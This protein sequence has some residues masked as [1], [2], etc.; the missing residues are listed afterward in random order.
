[1]IR[2]AA[3]LGALL[4]VSCGVPSRQPV[5]VKATHALVDLRGYDFKHDG[6]V[7]PSHWAW[8]AGT[9]WSPA[10][11]RPST[12][13]PPRYL[14][15]PE[16][17]GT[18]VDGL[19]RPYLPGES[20]GLAVATAQVTFLV[21]PGTSLGLQIG[22]FPGAQRVWVNGVRVLERGTP[23]LD[24]AVYRAGGFG[25]L[26]AVQPR[27]GLLSIVVEMATND[28]LVYH[29]ELGRQW[30]LESFETMELERSTVLFWHGMQSAVITFTSLAFLLLGILR[31]GRK[32][33]L[34]VALFLLSCLFKLLFTV[35][36]AQPADYLLAGIL[37]T[38][39]YL[40]LHHGF[41]LAPLPLL[42]W[43]LFQQFPREFSVRFAWGFTL[44]TL[45]AVIW[46]L[47][48]LLA[49][50]GGWEAIYR[51]FMQWNWALVVGGF[52][53]ASLLVVLERLS[54]VLQRRRPMAV[55]YFLA[56]TVL[57]LSV[58]LPTFL[59]LFFQ[60][61]FTLYFGWGIA[62]FLI[63]VSWDLI[64]LDLRSSEK[65]IWRLRRRI[66][67]LSVL[68]NF[69]SQQWT[70]RMGKAQT[71][72]LRSG[73]RQATLGSLVDVSCELDPAVW[74]TQ[75]SGTVKKFHA[76]LLRSH[77]ERYVWLTDQSP[78]SGLG[79]AFELEK[80]LHSFG[81]Q[82]RI[83]VIGTVGELRLIGGPD[84]WFL[85]LR[86][87]PEVHLER[88]MNLAMATSAAVVVDGGLGPG[89]IAG[90]WRSY[91]RLSLEG[92]EIEVFE[93]EPE[94]FCGLKSQTLASYEEALDCFAAG[95]HA[96][97]RALLAEVLRQNPL[98]G[99][100]RYFLRLSDKA[101]LVSRS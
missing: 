98:D 79:M 63:V 33:Q 94:P 21:P 45:G 48:P 80:I 19:F 4:L 70:F 99:A 57:C 3:L 52:A 41:N 100:A 78:E 60:T 16:T 24:Q 14:P 47:V 83:V 28:P 37:G 10:G 7:Y 53:V 42:I 66:L 101:S 90:G 15:G 92:T 50:A 18:L 91:R 12:L 62:F 89:L 74:L 76:A 46:Q 6:P 29:F 38:K 44:A 87:Y 43:V 49:L 35:E 11:G 93:G 71:L 39:G 2:W 68:G 73:D 40:F 13:L 85:S 32:N 67:E 54:V 97:G 72:E 23:S 30:L 26:V 61:H 65:L 27:D 9:L 56:G 8:D 22:W 69:V 59:S 77:A 20:G 86:P 96:R 88:L 84:H 34:A 1:M 5:E 55:S 58:M 17:G 75:A 82:A 31:G 95:D 81:A 64:R 25:E 51:A 36:L